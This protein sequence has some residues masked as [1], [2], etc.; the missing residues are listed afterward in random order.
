MNYAHR[1]FTDITLLAFNTETTG[2]QP[3]VQRLV[4]IGAVR[5]HLDG[6]E[7]ATFE[8][9]IDPQVPIPRDVQQVHGITDRMVRGQP[10]IDQSLPPFIQ[11]IGSHDPILLAHNSP[12]DLGF[13]A[14]ALIR[15][16]I[17][18]PPHDVFDRP[19]IAHRLYPTWHSH[20]LEHVA[21]RLKSA[22]AVEHRALSDARLVKAT[23]LAML[24]DIPT[25]K[26]TA[27]VM[28]VSQPHTIADAPLYAIEPSSGFDV[29]CSLK[30]RP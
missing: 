28:R 13:L 18:Y 6:R 21:A 25:G 3:I 29:T 16:G 23:F 7:L 27:D 14:M 17:A 9:L 22:N 11:F 2:L 5:F 10:T 30:T 1:S 20:R 12:F 24:K 8:Q 15:L 4:E 19:D 26:T